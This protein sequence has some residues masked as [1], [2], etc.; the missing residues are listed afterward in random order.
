[1]ARG[2]GKRDYEKEIEDAAKRMRKYPEHLKAARTNQTWIDFLIDVAGVDPNATTS[3][4]AQNFWKEVQEKIEPKQAQRRS[5][6]Q[7]AR[8]AG[9]PSKLARRV[10]DWSE[11]RA[12][13]AIENWKARY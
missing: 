13:E 6:Y 11:E 2:K 12:T 1:M 3:A 4:K 5:L 9:M 10:R 8:Q 7:E